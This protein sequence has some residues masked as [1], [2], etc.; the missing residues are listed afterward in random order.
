M[1]LL[2]IWL[3]ATLTHST[4]HSKT[5]TT[6]PPTATLSKTIFIGRTL[7]EFNQD[8]FLGIKY[9]NKPTRFTPSSL[10]TT[11]ASN[12]SNSG[13]Y[14]LSVEGFT[15]HNHV[16]YNA[17]EYGYDCPAYG[18]D[19]TTLVNRGLA[20]LD[21]DCLNLNIIRPRGRG[22]GLP[23]MLWIY[24]GGWQQGATADPRYVLFSPLY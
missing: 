17:S 21:E 9:A 10:K 1:L 18:S 24:G 14:D 20:R 2:P 11:Y 15:S 16:Y 4:P 6:N 12:D 23:V 19:T 8:L 5:T 13:V 7:P 3:L 22:D